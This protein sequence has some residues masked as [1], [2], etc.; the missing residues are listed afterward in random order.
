MPTFHVNLLFLSQPHT[1]VNAKE[2]GASSERI[3]VCSINAT[4]G[5]EAGIVFI[6]GIE[7]LFDRERDLQLDEADRP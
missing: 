7:R 3:R 4:T 1:A 5:L 6:M 2:A